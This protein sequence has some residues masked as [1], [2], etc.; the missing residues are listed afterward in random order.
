[1]EKVERY[2]LEDTD[3]GILP[4]RV[5]GI[6]DGIDPPNNVPEEAGFFAD[7]PAGCSFGC[8]SSLNEAFR[9]RPCLTVVG[10]D[11]RH[12]RGIPGSAIHHTAGGNLSPGH[13]GKILHEAEEIVDLFGA[14]KVRCSNCG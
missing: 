8:L 11:Q 5:I 12:L 14:A 7:F 6:F 13:L 9:K 2:D 1:M 10:L 4:A 3:G